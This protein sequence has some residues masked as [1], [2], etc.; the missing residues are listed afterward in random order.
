MDFGNKVTTSAPDLRAV[1]TVGNKR[2]RGFIVAGAREWEPGLF[3]EERYIITAA[4]CLP[5]LPPIYPDRADYTYKALVGRIGDVGRKNR[6]WAACVIADA[7]SDIAVFGG[8]DDQALYSESNKYQTMIEDEEIVPFFV[9]DPPVKGPA[10]LLSL[11]GRWFGCSVERHP[12]D[13]PLWITNAEEPIVGGMSGSPVLAPDGTA[14]G[15]VSISSGSGDSDTHREG[16]SPAMMRDL[17][18]WLCR[19]LALALANRGR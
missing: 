9:S 17:P 18:A 16:M 2:G 4:H 5:K 10:L 6:V 8:P 19:R 11:D 14:I 12:P 1:V 15:V 7:M 3:I 13:G